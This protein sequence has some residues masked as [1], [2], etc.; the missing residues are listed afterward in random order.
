MNYYNKYIKYKN[1]YLQL[2]NSGGNKIPSFELYPYDVKDI[3]KGT[4]ANQLLNSYKVELKSK[5]EIYFNRHLIMNLD[6]K[7]YNRLLEVVENDNFIYQI[8]E[9]ENR[10]VKNGQINYYSIADYKYK[11]YKI[12][13]DKYSDVF[14]IKHDIYSFTKMFPIIYFYFK[15]L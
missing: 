1:K 6:Q 13:A 3:K 9:Q 10:S 5:D 14:K 15:K 12:N 7:Q 2:K 8:R 11:K 4:T